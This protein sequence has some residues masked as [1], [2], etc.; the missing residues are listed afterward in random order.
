MALQGH[1]RSLILAPIENAYATSYRL[2]IVTTVLYCPLSEI[3]QVSCWE[4][5]PP[6]FH[7]NFRG[8]PLGLGCQF[9]DSEERD[10]KLIIRIINF[11]LVQPICPQYIN[12][13]ERETDGRTTYDSNMHRAV[14]TK[15]PRTGN[16][17]WADYANVVACLA[18][19]FWAIEW[20]LRE[21][22]VRGNSNGFFRFAFIYG[23]CCLFVVDK[24]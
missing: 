15:V 18:Y 10:P 20:P 14:I 9:C 8:V 16:Y 24:I 5:P 22:S 11:E 19:D 4:L 12:V 13:T 21:L 3:L 23:K 17:W 7:P 6:L 1:P 2:S